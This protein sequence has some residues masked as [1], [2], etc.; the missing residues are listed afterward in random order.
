MTPRVREILGWYGCDN[1]GVLKGLAQ[2]LNHGRIAGSGK[3]VMTT[4]LGG[5]SHSTP[6]LAYG[7]S[8][9][10]YDPVEHMVLAMEA[11]VNALVAP[12]GNLQFIARNFAGEV[13]LFLA[14]NSKTFSAKEALRLGCTGVLFS[15]PA[16]EGA[17]RSAKE[18]GLV[19][20]LDVKEESFDRLASAAYRAVQMGGHIINISQPPEH[21]SEESSAAFLRKNRVRMENLVERIRHMGDVLFSGQRLFT[22]SLGQDS[23]D[24]DLLKNMKDVAQGGAFGCMMGSAIYQGSREAGVERLTQ[25]M[26][27]LVGED[28]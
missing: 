15:G 6:A 18:N 25:A 12:K 17:I 14:T 10:N 3:L 11:R 21:C 1:A 7:S 27:T 22:V 24:D 26:K 28:C 5:E 23:S 2:I 9:D 16:E 4:A 13:P 19:V 20:V 8:P